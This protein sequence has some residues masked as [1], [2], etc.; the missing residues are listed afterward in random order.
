MNRKEFE[1]AVYGAALCIVRKIIAEHPDL[2]E[3]IEFSDGLS[4][5]DMA[6]CEAHDAILTKVDEINDAYPY[7][8]WYLEPVTAN[9]MAQ[10]VVAETSEGRYDIS[11]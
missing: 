11:L 3:V 2:E 4:W 5:K 10:K 1:K 6:I 8:N 7:D 9:Q